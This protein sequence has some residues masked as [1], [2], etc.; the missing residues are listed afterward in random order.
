M[1]LGG[2]STIPKR[3]SRA[4]NGTLQTNPG[5]R[6]KGEQVDD[7]KLAFLIARESPTKSL[8]LEATLSTNNST[9]WY[10]NNC[11]KGSCVCGPASRHCVLSH[12]DFN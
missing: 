10:L 4:R 12:S 9:E 1:R 8:C 6:S 7:Q 3:S 5:Q 11:A 2:F